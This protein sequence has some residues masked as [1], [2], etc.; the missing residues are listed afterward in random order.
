[1]CLST[2]ITLCIPVTHPQ[3]FKVPP[4]PVESVPDPKAKGAPAKPKPQPAKPLEPPPPEVPP[5]PPEPCAL[6]TP[7]L[8]A[9]LNPIVVKLLKVKHLPD[10]PAM[11]AQLDTKCEKITVHM[12]WP[13]QVCGHW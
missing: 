2:P 10:Q 4:P 9:R 13:G 3:V 1:M 6:F 11:S 8:S 12:T 7:E 5:P